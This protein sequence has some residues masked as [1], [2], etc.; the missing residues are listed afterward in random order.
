MLLKRGLFLLRIDALD[1]FKNLFKRDLFVG[2]LFPQRIG[3]RRIAFEV[4]I[5]V[6]RAGRDER[7]AIPFFKPTRLRDDGKFRVGRVA[8]VCQ[9]AAGVR[10]LPQDLAPSFLAASSSVSLSMV[11]VSS[12]IA[13]ASVA[14]ASRV[15]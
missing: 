4:W 14:C 8:P 10:D 15:F 13:D 7:N 12:Q 3:N 5:R 11:A 6:E 2:R 1:V 9:R